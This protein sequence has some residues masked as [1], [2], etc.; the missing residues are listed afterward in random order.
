VRR[1]TCPTGG[2]PLSNVGIIEVGDLFYCAG[3]TP[4]FCV[5]GGEF[6]APGWLDCVPLPGEP[7]CVVEGPEY[8]M[9]CELP[10][11]PE[12]PEPQPIPEASGVSM[13][14]AGVLALG[15]VLRRLRR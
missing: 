1:V 10:V 7:L 3:R 2:N 15:L 4:S 8:V 6:S 12:P 11:P 9:Q 5:G 14:I 13:L